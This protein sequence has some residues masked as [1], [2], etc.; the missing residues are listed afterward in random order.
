VRIEALE[1]AEQVCL[2]ITDSGSGMD[3]LI[4]E[5]VFEPFFTTKRVGAGT[6]LGLSISKSILDD[7]NATISIDVDSPHT[8]F[9]LKFHKHA[10]PSSE[11]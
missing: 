9:R 4:A 11:L 7:H 6:G 2:M 8:C 10:E 3:E 1:N 5:R